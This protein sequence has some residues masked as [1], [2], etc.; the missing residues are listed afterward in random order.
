MPAENCTG[1]INMS[2]CVSLQCVIILSPATMLQVCVLEANNP[3]Y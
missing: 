3:E 2:H 1:P